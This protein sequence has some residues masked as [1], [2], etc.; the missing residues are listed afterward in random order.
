MRGGFLVRLVGFEQ[1]FQ[2]PVHLVQFGLFLFRQGC[3]F[4]VPVRTV[5]PLRIV[6]LQAGFDPLPSFLADAV[7]NPVPLVSERF[8]QFLI[9]NERAV[10]VRSKQVT[11][12]CPTGLFISRKALQ[13]FMRRFLALISPRVSISRMASGSQGR[14]LGM[15]R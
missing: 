12:Y 3:C 4:L 8:Q 5:R 6:A 2:F 1:R 9:D 7:G 14:Y 15:S 13:N 11:P 10:L